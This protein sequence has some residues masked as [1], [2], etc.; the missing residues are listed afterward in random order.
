MIL[1]HPF[2]QQ[3]QLRNASF[4]LDNLL[5]PERHVFL[6]I[7]TAFSVH[8][9]AKLILI[10]RHSQR[11]GQ[12]PKTCWSFPSERAVVC[13]S[14]APVLFSQVPMPIMA[15]WVFSNTI[16]LFIGFS[17]FFL[18]L[19]DLRVILK[20]TVWPRYSLRSKISEI[21]LGVQL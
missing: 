16:R 7:L 9:A 3:G 21:V 19:Y 5:T 10:V 15:S 6:Q 2:E 4:R 14:V 1:I 17:T 12:R 13:A 11:S 20:L 8:F 18:D